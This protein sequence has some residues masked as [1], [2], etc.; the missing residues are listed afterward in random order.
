MGPGMLTGPA[1]MAGMQPAGRMP[2]MPPPPSAPPEMQSPPS[3]G[4]VN[5]NTIVS[6]PLADQVSGPLMQQQQAAQESKLIHGVVIPIIQ[7][8]ANGKQAS[9]PKGAAELFNMLGKLVKAVPPV[10]PPPVGPGGPMAAAKG[11]PS[12][13]PSMGSAPPAPAGPGGSPLSGSMGGM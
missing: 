13:P 12:G 6:S 10:Q 9:D 4:G 2:S 11:L 7:K 5:A 8:I 1:G 3:P